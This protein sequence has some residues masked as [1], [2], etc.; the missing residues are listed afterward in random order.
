[1]SNVRATW[2][3]VAA[4]RKLAPVDL[5][6][7]NLFP[8]LVVVMVLLT[9]VSLFHVW[10]RVRLVELNLQI[11]E[12]NRVLKEQRQDSNQLRLEVASLRT[13]ARIEAV[14]KGEL[15]MVLPADQQTVV[16]K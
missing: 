12:A 4:P 7:W 14:A 6:R 2:T 1:M 11:G 5:L 13:P 9:L 16:V 8:Y 3:K 10:S 15:G